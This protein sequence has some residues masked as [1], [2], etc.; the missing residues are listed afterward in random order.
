VWVRDLVLLGTAT[1]CFCIDYAVPAQCAGGFGCPRCDVLLD[2]AG[3]A[4][5]PTTLFDGYI[6]TCT[7]ERGGGSC[8]T[9]FHCGIGGVCVTG[10]CICMDDWTCP[11]C[12]QKV[13]QDTLAG[14]QAPAAVSALLLHSAFVSTQCPTSDKDSIFV[15]A[16]PALLLPMAVAC[17]SLMWSATTM[18]AALGA[19]ATA[20]PASLA[21]AALNVYN[22]YFWVR[23]NCNLCIRCLMK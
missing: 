7:L 2:L 8:A 12:T 9:D 19:A 21:R 18:A 11:Y 6:D 10:K 22:R 16:Q 23:S 20:I 17:A 1:P 14:V 4:W 5:Q 13:K 3:S 15:Q